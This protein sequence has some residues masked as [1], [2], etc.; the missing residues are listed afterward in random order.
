MSPPEE[1]T[2]KII[3]PQLHFEGINHSKKFIRIFC[4][5][6]RIAL[7]KDGLDLI[8]TQLQK[9]QLHF[10]IKETKGWDTNVGCFLTNKI[11][12]R[13]LTHNVLA[14]EMAHA[15]ASESKID[16]GKEFRECV[17][18]DMQGRE[19]KIMTLKGEVKRLMVDALKAY[20]PHQFLGEIFARYFELLSVSRNIVATGDFST[21]DVMDF[22][23]NITNFIEK[24]F[25]PQIRKKI[26]S[27]ISSMT[28]QIKLP[29]L[30]KRFQDQINS[31]QKATWSGRT[32]PNN[33]FRIS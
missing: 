20:P 23:I 13:Q 30:E 21:L 33:P 3:A 14:H 15:L 12:I 6:Y 22:F 5:L 1:I 4:D 31:K 8:L 28:T 2:K 7:F 11:T 19:P 25:N 10:D 24:I 17:L 26:D 16:L 29:A 32:R 9:K 27:K 18:Y